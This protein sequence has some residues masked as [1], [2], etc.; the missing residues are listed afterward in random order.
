MFHRV[1]TF[2]GGQ[3]TDETRPQKVN[4]MFKHLIMNRLGILEE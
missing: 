4:K 2:V 1:A 3:Y